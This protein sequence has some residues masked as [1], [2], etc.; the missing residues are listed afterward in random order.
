MFGEAWTRPSQFDEA[1]R[2]GPAQAPM[3]ARTKPP[4]RSRYIVNI[5]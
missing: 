1:Q 5:A 2:D 3:Q 4:R